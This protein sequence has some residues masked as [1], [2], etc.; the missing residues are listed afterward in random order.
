MSDKLNDFIKNH[1]VTIPNSRMLPYAIEE[2]FNQMQENMSIDLS[3]LLD[4]CEEKSKIAY[5]NIQKNKKKEKNTFVQSFEVEDTDI[6]N[7]VRCLINLQN[8]KMKNSKYEVTND[9]IL[10][11]NMWCEILILSLSSDV[12]TYNIMK[13][14]LITG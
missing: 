6:N 1:M 9:E 13:R 2:L 5:K 11:T 14:G 10:V 7:K 3:E 12:I 8:T 4:E